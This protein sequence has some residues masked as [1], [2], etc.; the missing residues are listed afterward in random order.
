MAHNPS[1][2]APSVAKSILITVAILVIVALLVTIYTL[3]GIEP[4]FAGF[5][6]ALYWTAIKGGDFKEFLPTLVGGLG[7]LGLAAAL[8]HLPLIYGPNGLYAALAAIVLAIFL[9]VRNTV[10]VLIN[11]PFMLYLTVG[12][13][14]AVGKME[15][16]PGMAFALLIAAAFAG[17]LMWLMGRLSG[18]S[19]KTQAA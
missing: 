13:I 1:A 5:L 15:D 12:T 3:L 6:F 7:G 17:G 4:L 14:P 16:Y 11:T 18:N 8:H 19:S 2:A 9:Q 10:P